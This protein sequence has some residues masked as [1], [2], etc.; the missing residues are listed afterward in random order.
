MKNKSEQQENQE[1]IR[2]KDCEEALSKINING[3]YQ[4][5]AF[6]LLTI[7]Y[8]CTGA[9][10]T[11][12]F[13]FLEKDPPITCY[14]YEYEQ[15]KINNTTK[16]ISNTTFSCSRKEACSLNKDQV[17][18]YKFNFIEDQGYS[19]TNDFRMQCDDNVNIGLLA[20]LFFAGSMISS[21]LSPS[22]SDFIGRAKL[23]KTAMVIRTVFILIPLIIR[24][25]L[26]TTI[27]LFFLGF[28]NSMHS[29]IPYILLSEYLAKDDRSKYLTYMFMF[30]SFSGIFATLFFYFLQ[31]WVVFFAGNLLYGLIFVI[32]MK[33]LYES[34]K[35]LY[36]NKRYR[37]AEEILGKIAQFNKI[38]VQIIFEKETEQV[39][40]NTSL[41][42]IEEDKNKKSISIWGILRHPRFKLYIIIIPL[43]W[44]LDAFAFFAI[45]FMIKY[46][47]RDIY[48]MNSI[49]FLSE[50]V[51][52]FLSYYLMGFF[53]KRNVMIISFIISGLGFIIFYFVSTGNSLIPIIILCFLAKFGASVILNV[54][55]IFTND[56]FPTAIRGRSTAVCSF[57][58]KFGGI[59][60]PMIVETSTYTGLVSGLSC[61]MAA[62]ILI[63]LKNN[64]KNEEFTDE[65]EN[66]VGNKEM[67]ETKNVEVVISQ[68]SKSLGPN[69][70]QRVEVINSEN[71]RSFSHNEIK[72]VEIIN[73]ED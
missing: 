40:T 48:F 56:C 44:F 63:P 13:I 19:W 62:L 8:T 21:L 3:S 60:A 36:A 72:K 50:A 66:E 22:I 54:S 39:H 64:S 10:I 69:E 12:S 31:N 38:N 27:S 51:S 4:K 16:I 25:N 26:F 33:Y 24:S 15:D 49:L 20:S 2:V 37:E 35:F 28:L 17:S 67:S 70:I 45:N 61:I 29:T 59:I 34:P 11:N 58:G 47:N 43:I 68:D 6:I 41:Q 30:E 7:C 52:Y 42:V 5:L 9:F 71:S 46:L 57:L 23:I 14:K 18:E 73:S 1:C 55:S 32:L 53:G 65:V